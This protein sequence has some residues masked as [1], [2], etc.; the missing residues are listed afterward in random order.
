M[1][2]ILPP[3]RLGST[4]WDY[5][6]A[7]IFGVVNVTPDSFSDGGQFLD[8]EAAVA[9]GEALV[10][11]GA[12][13]LDIGGESTRPRSTPVPA[14]EERRRVLPVIEALAERV[15]VPL[16]IDTYKAD[17]ARAAVDAGATIINDISGGSLDE[18]IYAVAAETGALL[19]LGH[20]RGE[21]KTMMDNVHFDDV[22]DEVESELRERLR[23]AVAAGVRPGKLWVDPSVGFG[24]RA[25][26][27]LALIGAAGR[28]REALGYPIMIGPSRKSFIGQLTG[29]EADDRVMGSAGAACAALAR[30]ADALR[31]HDVGPLRD[32]VVVADAISRASDRDERDNEGEEGRAC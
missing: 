27:S 17:V 24:K 26:H 25:E 18:R 10:E 31:L 2:L 19:I 32:A 6:R 5:R 13:A 16:S 7:L 4:C 11:Q 8:H 23:R 12:D 20:L 28:L 9:R 30:G 1:S 15:S 22:V 3:I 14:D 21:P 29:K